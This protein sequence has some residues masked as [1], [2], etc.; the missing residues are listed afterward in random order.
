[1]SKGLLKIVE[2]MEEMGNPFM[3]ESKDLLRLDSRDIIDPVV[4]CSIHQAKDVGQKQYDA[5]I[6][7]RLLEQSVSFSDQEEQVVAV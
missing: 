2:V 5:F 7:D 3:E 6:T 1:M 4:A